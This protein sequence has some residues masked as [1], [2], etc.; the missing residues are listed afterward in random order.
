[1][2]IGNTARLIA[3]SLLVWNAASANAEVCIFV[4]Q[5]GFVGLESSEPGRLRIRTLG[6]F[7]EDGHIV[8]I[9]P[10]NVPA[11]PHPF[12]VLV[13]NDAR[14]ASMGNLFG[15]EV[16]FE[17][18][19]LTGVRYDVTA[20]DPLT[21]LAG[22]WAF[23]NVVPVSLSACK[24]VLRESKPAGEDIAV[25]VAPGVGRVEVTTGNSIEIIPTVDGHRVHFEVEGDRLPNLA[26]HV[27]WRVEGWSRLVVHEQI[28]GTPA[29]GSIFNPFGASG[30]WP[31][32][33]AEGTDVLLPPRHPG[34]GFWLITNP[35]C[36]ADTGGLLPSCQG[37]Y[38]LEYSIL[39]VEPPLPGDFDHNG[40]VDLNDFSIL[41]N[42]FGHQ[43]RFWKDGDA[44]L[45]GIVEFSDFLVLHNNFGAMSRNTAT[46]PETSLLSLWWLASIV[47]GS[48]RKR[49]SVQWFRWMGVAA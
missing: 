39:S 19:L 25:E 40:R 9:P 34:Y 17:G 45:N 43:L 5:N 16:S 35:Q 37:T 36:R 32:S 46:V 47:A 44:N 18:Q 49:P 26:A 41:A 24:P 13:A 29:I 38:T 12:Q 3:W 11:D 30:T 28:I 21:D 33:L 23:G 6:V 22:A 1:M 31:Q 8:P 4:D 48:R 14:N 7:S 42:N 27:T 10:G 15:G 20:G 2:A